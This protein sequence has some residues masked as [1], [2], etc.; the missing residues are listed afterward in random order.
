M[1][2][3]AYFAPEIKRNHSPSKGIILRTQAKRIHTRQSYFKYFT[4]YET[5]KDGIFDKKVKKHLQQEV[6]ACEAV[7][8]DC[9]KSAGGCGKKNDQSILNAKVIDNEIFGFVCSRCGREI[10]VEKPNEAIP[11]IIVPGTQVP[12]HVGLVDALGRPLAG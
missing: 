2:Q 8:F 6:P 12:K 10:E 11:N 3:E 4:V 9:P 5:V 1:I 7:I